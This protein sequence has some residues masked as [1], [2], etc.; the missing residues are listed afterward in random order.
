MNRNKN[1]NTFISKKK[2]KKLRRQPKFKIVRLFQE[3]S[4]SVL[5]ITLCYDYVKIYNILIIPL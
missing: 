3:L 1:K 5:L 2:P 4:M